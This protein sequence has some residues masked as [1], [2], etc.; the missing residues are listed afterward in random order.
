MTNQAD[1]G[2]RPPQRDRPSPGRKPPGGPLTPHDSVFRRVLGVPENMASQL[3]AVLPPN[4]ATQLDL[5]RLAR[6]PGSFVDEA[7]KWRHS[8][9]LFTAPL[10]GRDALVYVLVEHQSS[11]DPLMAFR[12]L[13]YVT[14][15][16]DRYLDEHPQAR[17]LPPVIPVVVHQG[18]GRWNSPEQL[19]DLIDL[20]PA[21]KN[22]MRAHLPTFGYL[23]DDLATADASQLRDRNL[24]PQALVTLLLLKTAPGNPRLP[25]ELRPWVGQLRAV[26]DSPGGGEAF[27]A[28]LTY[29][30]LVSEAPASELHDLAVSLGPNAE[31]A[32]MT[33]AEQLRAEGRAEALAEGRA[34]ALV[35]VL[36]VKF[37]TLPA[38]VPEKVRAASSGQVQE[39]TARAV[40]AEKLDEV[41]G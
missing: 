3:R 28:L 27:I 23:L 40:T 34:E 26:L 14:R 16:W 4:V 18:P 9:L 8:D 30:E 1:S 7:L 39:W 37:G 36:T 29:I 24:T 21:G 5:G 13:R 15:I 41:F 31:E 6:V 33:I 25:A 22:A 38:G 32:Y 10:E 2:D 20:D 17:R 35:Q 12:M 11:S 19:L